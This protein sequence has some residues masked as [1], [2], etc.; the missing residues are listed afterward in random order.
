M[1]HII[2]VLLLLV[3]N[4]GFSQDTFIKEID[5]SIFGAASTVPTSDN[6]WIIL[7]E[8]RPQL[9]KYNQCGDV[10]WSRTYTITN[11]N[12]CIGSQIVL[13]NQDRIY[14]LTREPIT[15]QSTGFRVTALDADGLLLWCNVYNESGQ[16][17][18]PYSLLID[19]WGHL[20]VYA[21]KSNV[22]N[23][24]STLT[25]IDFNGNIRWSKKYDIGTTWGETII[26]QDSGLLMR[27]GDEFIK[28]D[29]IG[30]IEW[31]SRITVG[32]TYYYRGAVEVTDGYFF[33]K[34]LK[35]TKEI[36][37]FKLDKQGN[38]LWGG[39]KFVPLHGI[40]NPL[41]NTPN[42]NFVAVLNTR[43]NQSTA[44]S[45]IIEFDKNL[46][47][48]KQNALTANKANWRLNNISFT[49]DNSPII[50]GKYEEPNI[51][52]IV[53]GKLDQDYKAGCDSIIPAPF[54]FHPAS[55]AAGSANVSANGITKTARPVSS[56]SVAVTDQITCS[57]T[58]VK[59]A[60]LANDTIICPDTNLTLQNL[61]TFN[62][63]NYTWSTGETTPTINVNTPGT[64]WVECS[65]PCVATI[66]TDTIVVDVTLIQDPNLATDTVLCGDN[67]ILLDAEIPFGQYLWQDN[68]T[69]PT[70][71]VTTSGQY[72]VD[73]TMDGC[74]KRFDSRI[75]SCEDY[76]IP[77]IFTPNSDGVNDYFEVIYQ[78]TKAFQSK[79]YNRWGV[80]QFESNTAKLPWDG[81]INGKPVSD[82]VYYYLITIGED[83][84]KGTLTII[85]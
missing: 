35:S 22:G 46:N 36:G 62:F 72:H 17:Y 29:S 60:T 56:A 14:L 39:G 45:V 23:G 71:L 30:Q 57:N 70:Y 53:F 2:W 8:D 10:E 85:R 61:S 5:G 81:T 67:T 76:Q 55:S 54:T 73:I 20:L 65:D 9:I 80:L 44:S 79:I 24:H 68:S 19:S 37:F 43:T 18:V 83:I 66:Y 27:R 47:I 84:I 42:G 48:I 64:Y 52:K 3:S 25:K 75:L 63:S 77:N 40:P 51:Q 13:D 11:Q 1:K 78:G 69:L 12:C 26:T 16:E 34:Q 59:V 21:N 33:T 82:G 4:L 50:I 31:I 28:M 41:K 7:L 49:K 6:G 32:N 58:N 38:L 74:V 15:Q